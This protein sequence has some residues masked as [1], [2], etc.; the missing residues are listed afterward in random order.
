MRGFME[1]GG[2]RHCTDQ[3]PRAFMCGG[4][5]KCCVSFKGHGVAWHS[6]DLV[7]GLASL[8]VE[9]DAE[10]QA[11]WQTQVPSCNAWLA[12]RCYGTVRH[13]VRCLPAAGAAWSCRRRFARR[14]QACAGL[15]RHLRCLQ[16][17]F[18]RY[19]TRQ[20]YVVAQC[21]APAEPSE[22][23][24]RAAAAAPASALAPRA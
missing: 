20:T 5:C 14:L 9:R 17:S 24:K 10:R 23:T 6:T 21:E 8:V 18:A 19:R 15:Q 3:E 4:S 1:T 13:T 7:V 11:L 2:I 16:L 22:P 12:R